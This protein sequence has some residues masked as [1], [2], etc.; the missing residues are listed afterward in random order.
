MD[1]HRRQ[2]V[3]PRKNKGQISVGDQSK[4]LTVG[5]VHGV[6]LLQFAGIV[7]NI[8]GQIGHVHRFDINDGPIRCM[9]FG[10][11]VHGLPFLDVDRLHHSLRHRARQ[12]D[13]QQ[14]VFHDGF[15]N[16]DAIRQ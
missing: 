12:I 4:L 3:L 16:L 5:I 10:W 15:P 6:Q 7:P 9:E 14:P 11:R 1:G 2:I 8:F 13:V